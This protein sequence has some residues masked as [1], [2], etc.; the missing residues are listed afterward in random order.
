MTNLPPGVTASMIPGNRLED[1]EWENMVI[2]LEDEANALAVTARNLAANARHVHALDVV[3]RSHIQEGD[4]AMT[5]SVAY[6]KTPVEYLACDG[7][8]FGWSLEDVQTVRELWRKGVSG[9][10]I[11]EQMRRDPD[12][13]A[14][15][16]IS[17]AKEQD[18]SLIIYPRYGGWEGT[19]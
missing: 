12:E 14:V 2:A 3:R 17:L 1:I 8:E 9:L 5:L 19:Q 10:K 13:V 4:R 11:S 7:M 6:V 15:L 16:I 18:E